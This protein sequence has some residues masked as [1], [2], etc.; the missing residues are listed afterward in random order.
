MSSQAAIFRGPSYAEYLDAD[1]R[2]VP[3]F[4]YPPD[5]P[6]EP[7]GSTHIAPQ[8]YTSQEF[9]ER[10]RVLLWPRVWQMACREEELARPGDVVIYDIVDW[11]F[12]ITRSEDGQLRGF[13]NSCPHRGRKLLTSER[14]VEQIRCGFHGFTWETDGTLRSLPCAWDF[15]GATPANW[16][17]REVQL[18]TWGGFVFLN[19]DPRARPLTEYLDVL[20]QHFARWRL[21]DCWKAAHVAKRIDCNWKVAQEAFM[22]S[23]H[24]IATHPQILE[25]IADANAQYDLLGKHVNRNM[26]AFGAS[27]PH[28][29]ED[30]VEP[31]RIVSQM[32]TLMRGGRGSDRQVERMS[33]ARRT[34][35]QIN[36]KAFQRAY[37]CDFEN[38]TDAE[39]LDAIVYNVFPNFSPWGGF[40]PNIIYRWRPDGAR[41]DSCLMEVM[42]L[43][44]LPRSGGRPAPAPVHWLSEAESWSSASELPVLGAVIDQDMLNMPEVQ[45]GLRG[46]PERELRLA[47]YQESRIRHFHSTLDL[48]L[49][50]GAPG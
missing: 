17:L 16:R 39:L 14:H 47:L 4:L 28:L 48:Y 45:K 31:Q 41:V 11:S 9:F 5:A 33:D 27:S 7:G 25:I 13:Y 21:E 44:R 19:M 3:A 26:A 50:A 32:L 42:L 34:L 2:D 6:Y 23:F 46:A 22:E 15:P 35:A 10:E 12:I 43:K 24:V 20:P 1:S 36:R 30:A 40:A 8:R 38:A 18:A 29:G 37:D 49:Q